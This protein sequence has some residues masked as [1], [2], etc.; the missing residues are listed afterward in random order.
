MPPERSP[1]QRACPKPVHPKTCTTTR[2]SFLLSVWTLNSLKWPHW[3]RKSYIRFKLS[4]VQQLLDNWTHILQITAVFPVWRF[5][6]IESRPFI[7]SSR[8][9]F[10]LSPQS[11]QT[12]WLLNRS[13]HVRP[14]G[15]AHRGVLAAGRGSPLRPHCPQPTF[16][17][18]CFILL[19]RPAVQTAR[20]APGPDDPHP[21]P[22]RPL[23]PLL[24]PSQRLG[25]TIQVQGA[26]WP[27]LGSNFTD[28][29][30]ERINC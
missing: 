23:W 24:L 14:Q 1:L 3:G 21:P 4:F 25:C 30:A 29:E 11:Q 6:L 19:T 18:C 12:S 16:W 5:C 7:F 13:P 8:P 10:S 15:R 26:V 17:V 22:P 28:T 20:P 27:T 9:F 2:A